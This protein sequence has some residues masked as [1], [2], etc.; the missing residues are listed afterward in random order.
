VA[1]L[2]TEVGHGNLGPEPWSSMYDNLET[3][4]ALAWPDSIRMYD[5]MRND[6]QLAAL[7][8]A[9]TLPI[10]RYRWF[11][12][13]NG[14]RDEVV[15][16]V[17]QN[18]NLPIKDTDPEPQRR[19]RGRFSH[20]KHLFQSLLSL[21]YGAMYFEQVYQLDPNQRLQLYKLA[22]RMPLTISEIFVAQDGGLEGIRQVPSGRPIQNG[23]I[24]YADL[25][26]KRIDVDKLVAYVHDQEGGNWRG[27]SILRPCYR[28]FVAKDKL[29]R[30]DIVRHERTGAG[31]PIVEAP[32]GATPAEIQVLSQLAM[33][34]R[35][36]DAAGGAVPYGAK[37]RLVG[38]EGSTP[39]TVESIR[40]QNQ[41]MSRA[42]L[43]MFMDLGTTAT[44]SRALGE[45]FTDFFSMAQETIANEYRTTTN[46]HVIEDLVDL[47]FGIDEQVPLLDYER[48]D[49]PAAAVVD[50]VAMTNV[51]LLTP[52]TGT[53]QYLRDRYKLPE[54]EVVEED[55]DTPVTVP[56]APKLETVAAR[57]ADHPSRRP[58]LSLRTGGKGQD[59]KAAEGD[60]PAIG[61]RDPNEYEQE[62]GTDFSAIDAAYTAALAALLLRWKSVVK[63]AMV[64]ELVDLLQK[65]GANDA[66]AMAELRVTPAGADVLSAAMSALAAGGVTLGLQEAAYQGV[67]LDAPDIAAL[68]AELEQT[69]QALSI[70]MA[71]SLSEAGTRH[72]L[73]LVGSGL[74]A[75]AIATAVADH[76]NSLSDAYVKDRLAAALSRAQQAGRIAALRQATVLSAQ[77][78]EILDPATC[79]SCRSID[80]TKYDSLEAGLVDYGSG[81]YRDCSGGD[82]CRGMLSVQIEPAP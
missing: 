1:K 29:M 11:I 54:G 38:V 12:D 41:E 60:P 48:D 69:A 55:P 67:Q 37:L 65:V 7:L 4:P 16:L 10:R 50:L 34:Y 72:A 9:L 26:G 46:E 17:A 52:D 33:A 66:V 30:I 82:R 27:R 49:D 74:T 31:V 8:L 71:S 45:S 25:S 42:F 76:L 47:N 15:Q 68:D 43:A 57:G 14:A 73:T 22:P 78:S 81:R 3:V 70:V 58:K 77:A 19:Q 35:A 6:S 13:P 59:V 20:D 51:G 44:G 36:G 75:V 21:V 80:G 24:S 64:A 28:P 53:E 5:K 56:T 39:D 18:F 79:P 2:E 40:L 32:E 61:N 63:P 23:L 62:A